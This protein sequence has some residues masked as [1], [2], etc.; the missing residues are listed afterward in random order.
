M[1]VGSEKLGWGLGFRVLEYWEFYRT[2]KVD[3]PSVGFRAPSL[4]IMP[5]YFDLGPSSLERS[6]LFLDFL[7]P[8]TQSPKLRWTQSGCECD[9]PL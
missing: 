8:Q 3:L 5:S 9:V 4:Y 6:C 1:Q 2:I 7:S